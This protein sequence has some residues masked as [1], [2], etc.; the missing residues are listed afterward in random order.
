MPTITI[1]FIPQTSA[2]E[3]PTLARWDDLH[4][5]HASRN[6]SGRAGLVPRRH[7]SGV[8]GYPRADDQNRVTPA[9]C[10]RRSCGIELGTGPICGMGLWN[11]GTVTLEAEENHELKDMTQGKL[12]SAS[13]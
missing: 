8:G 1:P 2:A 4:L 5:P 13:C 12:G 3:T 10:T 6:L 9:P 7:G 11:P